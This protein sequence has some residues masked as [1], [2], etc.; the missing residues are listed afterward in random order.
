M[1]IAVVVPT[2][3]EEKLNIFLEAWGDIFRKHNVNLYIVRDGKK[4]KEENYL[5]LGDTEAHIVIKD[6]KTKKH[7]EQIW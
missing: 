2:I 5:V 7:H 6:F 3:R 1:K 4:S